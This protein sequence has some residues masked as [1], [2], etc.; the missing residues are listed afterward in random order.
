M[1]DSLVYDEEVKGAKEEFEKILD[2]ESVKYT[3]VMQKAVYSCANASS[4][5]QA[6]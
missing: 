1:D 3:S 4:K 2:A 5:A 6:I